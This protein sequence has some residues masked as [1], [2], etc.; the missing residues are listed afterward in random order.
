[1]QLQLVSI[2]CSYA[3]LLLTQYNSP[4]TDPK[5]FAGLSQ[6]IEGVGVS[7]YTGA[8][9]FITDKGYLTAAA[10]V[11]ATE[12]VSLWSTFLKRTLLMPHIL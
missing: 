3:Q 2:G 5:S 8:A 6:A 11:L 1:L 7:A 12:A 9:Q 10:S 4:Y